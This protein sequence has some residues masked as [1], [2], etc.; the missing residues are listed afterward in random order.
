MPGITPSEENWQAGYKYSPAPFGI[1][2]RDRRFRRLS[3]ACRVMLRTFDT[4]MAVRAPPPLVNSSCF[5][6]A[7]RAIDS[8]KGSTE[9]RSTPNGARSDSKD[10][11]PPTSVGED[12]ADWRASVDAEELTRSSIFIDRFKNACARAWRVFSAGRRFIEGTAVLLVRAVV[13]VWRFDL[14]GSS[15]SKFTMSMM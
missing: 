10:A 4:W 9:E 8:V 11:T 13:A 3:T 5:M 12:R 2:N 7:P 14:I 6:A 15:Q 1:A